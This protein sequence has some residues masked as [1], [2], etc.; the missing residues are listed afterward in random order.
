MFLKSWSGLRRE[1]REL[2]FRIR[3][4]GDGPHSRIQWLQFAL[5]IAVPGGL[6]ISAHQAPAQSFPPMSNDPTLKPTESAYW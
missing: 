4:G 6:A 5:E 3:Q 1:H 2:V